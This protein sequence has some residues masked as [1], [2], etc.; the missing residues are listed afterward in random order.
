MTHC[1]ALQA[2]ARG[3]PVVEDPQELPTIPVGRG[4]KNAERR[5]D[6]QV[7][8]IAGRVTA[9][10]IAFHIF[11]VFSQLKMMKILMMD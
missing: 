9:G 4:G 8:S 2:K 6:I 5:I 11:N 3:T 1:C 7:S 10:H